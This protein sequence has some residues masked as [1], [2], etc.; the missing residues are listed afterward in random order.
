MLVGAEN[1]EFK[2][3]KGEQVKFV[4][5]HLLES[6]GEEQPTDRKIGRCVVILN[7]TKMTFSGACTMVG[8]EVLMKYEMRFGSDK[9]RFSGLELVS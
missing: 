7:T 5:L 3:D 6:D 2:N 8:H 4:R 9:A 1:V